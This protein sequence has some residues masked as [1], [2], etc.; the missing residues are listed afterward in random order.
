M[1]LNCWLKKSG[2]HLVIGS[3]TVEIKLLQ[4]K[5]VLHPFSCN[6][7]TVFIRCV[8]EH[9]AST[10]LMVWVCWPLFLLK[11]RVVKK[12]E[13]SRRVGKSKGRFCGV[14]VLVCNTCSEKPA[15]LSDY[16]TMLR[17][18][19]LCTMVFSLFLKPNILFDLIVVHLI[20]SLYSWQNTPCLAL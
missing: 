6:F 10:P 8:P 17:G 16:T 1:A 15:R 11:D 9:Q 7:W 13:S 3:C 12:I 5:L 18:L 14:W 4:H 2:S 20:C 19:W